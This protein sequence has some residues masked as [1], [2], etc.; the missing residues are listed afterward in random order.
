MPRI[1]HRGRRT[2]GSRTNGKSARARAVP[3]RKPA[4]N[5]T[6]IIEDIEALRLGAGIED[7][8]L[9]AAVRRLRAGALVNL[10]FLPHPEARPGQTLSVRITS[11]KGPTFRGT[12]VGRPT[13]A[14]LAGLRV[15]AALRFTADHIHSIL[16][17]APS[18]TCSPS[19]R[20]DP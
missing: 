7:T 20:T 6:V 4:G 1:I 2:N 19:L 11:R 5:Y 8:A 15:G 14:S 18:D 9:A 10:T 12:L 3:P 13:S 16:K 17:P